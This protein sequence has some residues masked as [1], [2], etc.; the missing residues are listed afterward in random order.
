MWSEQ[1]RVNHSSTPFNL[2]AI[3]RL[4]FALAI[5]HTLVGSYNLSHSIESHY[6]VKLD[7]IL[8]EGSEQVG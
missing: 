1:C 2:K 7:G 4:Y 3:L 6:S 8:I 5:L